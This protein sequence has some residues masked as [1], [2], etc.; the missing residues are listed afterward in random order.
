MTT[1]TTA[2]AAPLTTIQ[3]FVDDEWRV[4]ENQLPIISPFD[5]SVAATVHLSSTE[6][7]DVAVAVAKSSS[8]EWWRTPA[9]KRASVLHR[10]ADGVEERI[11]DLANQMTAE[12]GRV[13]A[14]ARGEVIRSISTLRISAEEATRISGELIPMDA[15][16]AGAGKL[17]FTLLSPVGVVAAIT[18]F[19]APL[20]TICHKLGPALAGGNSMILKPHHHGAGVAAI[21]AQICVS[22]GL[23]AGIFQ[24]VLGGPE[25]GHRLTT[26][27]DVSFVNFTGSDGVAARIL[28]EIGLKRTLLELGGNAP[29]I[30]HHDADLEAAVKQCSEAGFGLSGQS[31][32][33]TQRI[34]VHEY[35]VS[36]FTARLVESARAR[37]FRA[38][39]GIQGGT[40]PLLN[41]EI[42]IRVSSWITE[43]IQ[44]GAE[45]ACGGKR[46]YTYVE[47]T[48]LVGAPVDSKVVCQEIFGPVVVV[49]PYS[50]IEETFAAA[51]ASPWGLKAGIFTNSLDVAMSAA[52]ELEFGA[53]NINAAS[54]SRVDQEPSGGVKQSGWG[55]EGP[56][57]AI[58]EMM[59]VRM[60]SIAT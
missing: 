56:K 40:G 52:K 58:R 1:T 37:N 26:H 14:E 45:L 2:P 5:G 54:R 12:T 28:S 59:N 18:P 38:G 48:V 46:D 53:V 16:E 51:N 50:D 15:V 3:G 25:I 31:C 9:Y 39:P 42:A 20:N 47:P 4:S 55:K 10:I 17:G 23:P 33:S 22:A 43:A 44:E 41:E 8:R 36:E 13:P 34:Y 57:Y 49:L 11:D 35:V 21:L 24:V 7:V 6:D 32:I 27:P 29:T 19:N 60:I 30:V